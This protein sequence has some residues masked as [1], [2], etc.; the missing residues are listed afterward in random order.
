MEN[1]PT[2][3]LDREMQVFASAGEVD[4]SLVGLG[5]VR[6]SSGT[7]TGP[8]RPA[9]QAVTGADTGNS[10][11]IRIMPV[12]LRYYTS[13]STPSALFPNIRGLAPYVGR[14]AANRLILPR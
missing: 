7:Y 11:G 1:E 3:H 13:T 2:P 12:L 10:T 9:I 14:L 5:Y 4:S 8:I 6:E